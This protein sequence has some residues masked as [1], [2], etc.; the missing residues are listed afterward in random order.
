[1]AAL[2][3]LVMRSGPHVGMSYPLETPEIFIG[4]DP[5]NAISINDTEISRNHA[6]LSLHGNAYVI[7]DLGSTNGTFVNGQ[8]ISGTQVLNPGD[9]ISLGENIV[10][11]YESAFDAGATVIASQAPRTLIQARRPEPAAAPAPMPAAPA[12]P[13]Y[14]AQVP[15]GPVQVA[16]PTEKKGGGKIALILI[17]V[18]ALCLIMACIAAFIWVDSDKSGARWCSFPFS[19]LAQLLGGVCP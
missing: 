12:A 19:F 10:L 8:R 6:K 11:I 14:A 1:M 15:A 4:R 16:A 17:I 2:F 7:Q 18:A 9:S 3:N 13:V 5:A